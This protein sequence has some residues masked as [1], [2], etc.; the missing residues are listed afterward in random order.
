M[1]IEEAVLTI[2]EGR[3]GKRWAISRDA[4]RKC[5]SYEL[6][7]QV[8]DRAIR[9]AV[10]TLRSEGGRGSLIC[11]SSRTRGYYMAESYEDVL[12]MYREERR[13][14]MTLLVRLRKQR[15]AARREFGGQLAFQQ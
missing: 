2:L 12:K 13:R 4:L 5:V 14:A 11:S 9:K 8:K 3:R 15:D 7:Q 1:T 10:E 6:R